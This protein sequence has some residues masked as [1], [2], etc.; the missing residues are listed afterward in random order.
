[1]NDPRFSSCLLAAAKCKGFDWVVLHNGMGFRCGYVRLLPGHP[2]YGKHYDE[3]DAK[4]H[5]GLTYAASDDEG[6][7]WV[8]FDCGHYGDARDLGLPMPAGIKKIL[9]LT[10]LDGQ[11]IRTQEYVEQQ[12]R[13]LCEQAA[14]AVTISSSSRNLSPA[15][16]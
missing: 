5:G 11:V 4:V 10:P 2:W 1:M 3:I 15:P 9:P 12:C 8:G 7:W 16:E 6:S 13:L 14:M